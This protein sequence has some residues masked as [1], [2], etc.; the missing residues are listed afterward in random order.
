M[1]S[2]DIDIVVSKLESL[3]KKHNLKKKELG[4]GNVDFPNYCIVSD[5][6]AIRRSIVEY[7]N[8][9]SSLL[10]IIKK[11][12]SDKETMV[13]YYKDM[14]NTHKK[15]DIFISI[16][17][18]T[19]EITKE[20]LSI[21]ETSGYFIASAGAFDY[22][23]KDKNQIQHYLLNNKKINISIEPNFDTKVNFEGDYLYHTTEKKYLEKILLKGLIPKSKN[24]RSFYP[25][26]IY[27]SPD[28]KYMKSIQQQLNTDKKGDYV[29]LKIDNFKGLSLY[30]DVR[31]KGGFY[32]YDN[33]SPKY[34]K[35]VEID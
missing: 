11:H 14:L 24:T 15:G 5:R 6:D 25:E 12:N 35:V 17:A 7:E 3:F 23:V 16:N 10:K 29:F 9:D 18:N 13:K 21:I 26:R 8:A 28:I 31:F 1:N 22:R 30:K 4:D 20:L 2:Y 32:T 33:I 19:P 34:I 27:L